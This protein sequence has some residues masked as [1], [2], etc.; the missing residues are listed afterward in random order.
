MA[1]R[2]APSPSPPA[3]HPGEAE[4]FLIVFA[5]QVSSL[6]LSIPASQH[7][8]IPASQHPSIPASQ[9][10]LRQIMA[11]LCAH[12]PFRAEL[13]PIRYGL[14]K[15]RYC[16]ETL[17]EQM[18]RSDRQRTANSANN[19]LRCYLLSSFILLH[20]I[21]ADDSLLTL[22]KT[23]GHRRK[24]PASYLLKSPDTLRRAAVAP[25]ATTVVPGLQGVPER[26]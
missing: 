1:R 18:P 26:R 25:D 19:P 8:S 24:S 4:N 16:Q 21:R 9:H 23:P 6:I 20:L 10:S 13:N 11:T 12:Q 22:N 5:F 2:I 17:H 14:T 7:S 3:P 15:V